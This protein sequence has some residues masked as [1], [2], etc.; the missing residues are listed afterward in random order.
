MTTQTL[1][2]TEAFYEFLGV[3]IQNGGCEK[4]P[5][6]LLTYWR[7]RRAQAIEDIEQGERDWQ[8]G[9]YRSIE[10]TDRYIRTKLGFAPR[11]GA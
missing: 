2:D 1:T 4:S 6:E 3:Q 7:Q 9:R 11:E 5:E 8:A 10:E